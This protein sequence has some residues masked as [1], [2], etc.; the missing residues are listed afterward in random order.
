M[1]SIVQ[2]THWSLPLDGDAGDPDTGQ[3]MRGCWSSM[4]ALTMLKQHAGAPAGQAGKG[5][6]LHM[7]LPYHMGQS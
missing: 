6:M 7:K 4:L 2:L 3:P 5:G 1:H